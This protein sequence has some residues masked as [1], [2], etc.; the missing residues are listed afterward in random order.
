[1]PLTLRLSKN[2]ELTH[3]ELDDNFTYLEDLIS[4][5]SGGS[6]DY[7]SNI[8]LS[9]N[10]LVVTGTGSAFSG[11]VDLSGIN[12]DTR[13]YV[14][15][16]TFANGTLSF[17]GQGSAFAS[18][19]DISGVNTDTRDYISSISFANNT[20]S[21]TGVGAAADA[22]IDLGSLA[23]G[24]TDLTAFSVTT[25][26]ASGGGSLSYSNT[27]GQFTFAPA[28]L[29]SVSGSTDLGAFSVTTATASGSGSLAYSNSTGVFTFTPVVF[30]NNYSTFTADGSTTGTLTPNGSTDIVYFKGGTNVTITAG[31]STGTGDLAGAS[32]DSLTFDVD[33]SSVS[34]SS[35]TSVTGIDATGSQ[36]VTANPTL[37]NLNGDSLGF[38]NSTATTNHYVLTWTLE[39]L[40]GEGSQGSVNSYTTRVY[41]GPAGGSLSEQQRWNDFVYSP[42]QVTGLRASRTFTH[43]LLNLTPSY[44]AQ[45]WIE[46]STTLSIV[47]AQLS[48]VEG[49]QESVSAQTIQLLT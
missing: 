32:L 28:D 13:D 21:F 42:T 7:V 43:T 20:L 17:T 4:G 5:S 10:S 24:G 16:V 12:T 25:E 46:G 47:S 35:G 36:A 1:M 39:F 15:N 8:T 29:S 27:N 49:T 30:P 34:G 19:V 48:I 2:T 33:L 41:T 11:S 38:V 44:Q 26:A 3:Q 40:L 45:I 14:S 22:N 9:N 31:T 18:T 6:I 37:I 23:G